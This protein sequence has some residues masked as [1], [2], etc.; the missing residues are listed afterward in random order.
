[1]TCDPLPRRE[2]PNVVPLS[3]STELYL[4]SL[5]VMIALGVSASDH[6]R[7]IAEAKQCIA[8]RACTRPVRSPGPQSM[9]P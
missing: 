9:R 2:I 3:S 6:Q 4:L 8:R 1:M 5:P 7:T